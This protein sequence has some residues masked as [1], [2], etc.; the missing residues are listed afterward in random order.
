LNYDFRVRFVTKYRTE[1]QTDRQTDGRKA[2]AWCLP[3][4]E[5]DIIKM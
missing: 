4:D 5:G 3:A 1:K 2:T